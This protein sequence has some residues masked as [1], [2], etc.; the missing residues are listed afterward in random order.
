MDTNSKNSQASAAAPKV[1]DSWKIREW[2]P[3]ISEATDNK[4]KLFCSEVK[5]VNSE[6]NLVSEKTVRFIDIIHF[7]DSIL[8]CRS[9]MKDQKISSIYDV[10]SGNGFPG[11][12]MAILY[13]EV[14]VTLVD[15]EN[16]RVSFMKT[17]ISQLDLKNIEVIGKP[18]ESFPPGS[19]DVAILRG[20]GTIPKAM[21]SFR[22][23]VRK[24]GCIYM[25]KGEEWPKEVTDI[26]IQLCSFWLP[27][28]VA[29]YNLPMGE[30][31]FSVVKLKKISD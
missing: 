2:F 18:I 15:A 23:Q 12:V 31:K 28:L 8:C 27:S 24:N 30:Y 13:P 6:V 10:G 16:R 21:L 22:K 26:P 29:D 20:F 3:D 4:L 14:K 7:A 17:V 11:L 25:I 5:R 19:F 9:I 1:N